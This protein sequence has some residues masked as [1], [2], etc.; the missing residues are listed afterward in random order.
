MGVSLLGPGIAP[1]RAV[2]A[3]GADP[4]VQKDR[5]YHLRKGLMGL[6][7]AT[8]TEGKSTPHVL[9]EL[10]RALDRLGYDTGLGIYIRD[11]AGWEATSTRHLRHCVREP[12]ADI[13][14]GAGNSTT[15]TFGSG[16]IAIN[17]GDSWHQHDKNHVEELNSNF[18]L[19]VVI[20]EA[21]RAAFVAAGVTIPI[22]P[23]PLGVDA[24]I[25]RPWP[26]DWAMLDRADWG[27]G[28]Q[29]PPEGTPLFIMAGFMQPRKGV[30]ETIEAFK[31]AFEPGDAA[32][33][34]KEVVDSHGMGQSKLIERERGQHQIGLWSGHVSEWDMARL[35][36]TA[37]CYASIHRREGFGLMPLQAMAC[38]TPAIITEYDGPL[39]YATPENSILIKPTGLTEP[40][41]QYP[42]D[43]WATIDVCA[44]AEAMKEAASGGIEP[45]REKAIA[46][47]SMWTWKRAAMAFAAAVEKHVSPLRRRPQPKSANDGALTIAFPVK[48]GTRHVGRLLASAA[49]TE[50]DGPVEILAL[51]DASCETEAKALAAMAGRIGLKVG[52]RVL[53]TDAP[54]GCGAARQ[55]LL[56]HIETEWIF[57]TDCDVEFTDPTWAKT[58]AK[59]HRDFGGSCSL[60]PLLLD[61]AGLVWSAGG[62][63]RKF[64]EEWMSAGHEYQ[65]KPVPDDLR[66]KLVPY[67]PGAGLFSRTEEIADLRT[68]MPGYFPIWWEDVDTSFWLWTQ[69]VR[70]IFCPE[71]RLIHHHGSF[72]FEPRA[73]GDRG[74]SFESCRQQARK[75]WS[76]VMEHDQ[77]VRQLCPELA[78]LIG[79]EKRA[80]KRL[81]LHGPYLV[82]GLTNER[83]YAL[84]SAGN[85]S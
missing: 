27:P 47:A 57:E 65:G 51:D 78:Y 76:E 26:K 14:W 1:V 59:A 41:P 3:P 11:D 5:R 75:W 15:Y 56:S 70:I 39:H 66:A 45:L 20:S 35:L 36:A 62:T 84:A 31:M 42:G 53:R 19:L 29:T 22:E 83:H 9:R 43:L 6:Q 46:T 34:I 44:T 71:A 74:D 30:E 17:A 79:G 67:A 40:Q 33:L 37:D 81:P 82:E 63:Y 25:Y 10:A 52:F 72:T 68:L 64:G 4:I 2:P 8:S 38:G 18:D 28:R 54:Q 80:A 73:P 50:W 16:R 23:I 55:V 77:R 58:L 85:A 21:C 69:G 24:N 32:L 7:F 49:K 61:G 12:R 13:T 60:A 48:D